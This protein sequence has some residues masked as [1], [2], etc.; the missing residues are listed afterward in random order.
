MIVGEAVESEQDFQAT[1]LALWEHY[2]GLE[3]A[4]TVIAER[5]TNVE[6]SVLYEIVPTRVVSSG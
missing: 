2:V 6:T 1:R 5:P 3:Q 4:R